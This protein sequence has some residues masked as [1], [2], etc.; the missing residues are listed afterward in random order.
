MNKSLSHIA[1]MAFITAA[2]IVFDITDKLL[3]KAD[4]NDLQQTDNKV[5]SET[6]LTA[7]DTETSDTTTEEISSYETS[8][9]ESETETESVTTTELKSLTLTYSGEKEIG[10]YKT[11]FTPLT[12]EQL[13]TLN[14]EGIVIVG[15]SIASGYKVYHRLPD[16]QVMA[17]GS[18]GAR[19]IHDFKVPLNG[20]EYSVADSIKILQPKY[21]CI[22]MGM[23]DVNIG[24]MEEYIQ[25]YTNNINEF[26][27]VSPDS[28][29]I[30]MAITPIAA[31][32]THTT[33][34]IIDTYN[35]ALYE[36]V[37]NRNDITIYYVNAAQTIKDSNNNLAASYSGG[38]GL[39]LAPTAYDTM[40]TYLLGAL[41]EIDSSYTNKISE[42]PVT[43]IPAVTQTD[44]NE[45]IWTQVPASE[46]INIT[47]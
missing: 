29:I 13:S 11:D 17:V 2:F 40:L 8:I 36:M 32:S 20:V 10:K 28:K 33:N 43:E 35:K 27:A 14:T 47:Q 38:D 3:L 19:N 9:S 37:A 12:N 34:T 39:H 18:L 24:T 26:L 46:T 45:N 7:I 30:V 4:D 41:S 6:V 23:N 16:N 44:A 5:V 22:S 31:T 1:V 15:D 25:N 21:I 42:P